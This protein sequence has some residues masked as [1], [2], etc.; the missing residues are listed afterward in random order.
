[1]RKVF[2]AALAALAVFSVLPR[3]SALAESAG[4]AIL[5]DADSGRVLFARNADEKRLIASTT[6]LMTALVAAQRIPDLEREVTVRAEWLHTEGSSIYLRP[7][8]VITVEALL[9]GLLLESGNDAADVLAYVC[10]GSL[11]AFAELMNRTA[12]RLGMDSSH[13]ANPSGLND[14]AHY[15]TARDMAVLGAACLKNAVVAKIC[16]QRT[17]RFGERT[18]R[19]HNRLLGLYE[20][21]V[22][23]KTGYTRLAGRTLVSAARRSGQTLVA[24]TLNDPDDWRT[25]AALLDYGFSAYPARALC[26]AGE[27]FGTVPV[28]GSLIPFVDVAAAE[29]FSY[30]LADGESAQISVERPPAVSAP[31]LRGECAGRMVYHLNGAVIGEVELRYVQSA[32]R[33]ALQRQTLLQRLLS[34]ILGERVTVMKREQK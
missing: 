15:S 16:A 29:T 21:C 2:A 13:F 19:N 10:A 4:S 22:G 6:K 33:D 11:E 31:V 27:V 34:A 28:A 30:P 12:A 14:E 1:M 23:M 5:M 9:C 8:E 17:T 26:E 32:Y 3:A 25:H 18:F 24:V 20:G 7:G